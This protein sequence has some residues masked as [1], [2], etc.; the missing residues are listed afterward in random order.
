MPPG[1]AELGSKRRPLEAAC[2]PQRLACLLSILTI[3]ADSLF[4]MVPFF[5]SHSTGTVYLPA[6]GLGEGG[7]GGGGGWE[8]GGGGARQLA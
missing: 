6:A 8:V 1:G 3:S 7:G 5:L 4:T 2:V